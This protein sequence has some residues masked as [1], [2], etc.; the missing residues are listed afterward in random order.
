MLSRSRMF[1]WKKVY[2]P[3]EL[4]VYLYEGKDSL[5]HG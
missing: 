4:F 2:E 1:N 3:I 5:F